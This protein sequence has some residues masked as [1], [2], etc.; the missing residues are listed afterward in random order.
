M[1]S[2]RGLFEI[3]DDEQNISEISDKTYFSQRKQNMKLSI[4]AKV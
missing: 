4:N 3:N 2:Q 1:I